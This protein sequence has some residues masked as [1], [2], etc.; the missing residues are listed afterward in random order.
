MAYR[1]VFGFPIIDYYNEIGFDFEKESF[2]EL[3]KE[4]I[5]LYH[6]GKTGNCQLDDKAEYILKIAQENNIKQI[7]LSA[8]EQ[9][10]LLSQIGEF[11][12]HHYFEDI[13]GLSDIYGKSKVDVGLD[14]INEKSIEKALLIGDT[15]HDYEVA[16]AMGCDCLLVAN[17]HQSKERLQK[18]GVP[19]LDNM[20]QVKGFIVW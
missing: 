17:G 15:R 19:V 6:R 14:Y 8:S 13:L 12:I 18:C 7:I 3:A 5:A 10:N 4:Y 1:Q 16:K 9:S 20:L 2:D 11:N